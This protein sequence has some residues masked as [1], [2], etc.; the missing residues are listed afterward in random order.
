MF[1]KAKRGFTLVEIMIVVAIIGILVAIAVP[2]FLKARTKAQGNACFEAQEKLEGA[3]DTWALDEGK[4]T[5]DLAVWADLVGHDSYL[6]R[7][8]I[9]PLDSDDSGDPDPLEIQPVG[10]AVSCFSDTHVR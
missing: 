2:G 6:K 5:G 7:T 1:R 4:T 9:C 3:I 10:T 8:P